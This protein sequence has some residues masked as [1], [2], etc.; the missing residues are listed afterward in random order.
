MISE[1][2][3]MSDPNAAAGGGNL[4]AQMMPLFLI[5]FII[6]FLMI[7]PQVKRQKQQRTMLDSLKKGDHVV[8]SGGI[9]GTIIATE[10]E[11]EDILIVKV[12]KDVKLKVQRASIAKLVE[13]E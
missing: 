4:F 9:I 2:Y 13:K 3:A 8:T 5:L 10:G 7:R 1:L 12:D 6:Y 11:K